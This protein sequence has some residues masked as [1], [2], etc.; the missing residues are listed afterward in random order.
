MIYSVHTKCILHS[1]EDSL[2]FDIDSSWPATDQHS[3]KPLFPERAST[4]LSTAYFLA[5]NID[6]LKMAVIE[7]CGFPAGY[8]VIRSV[9]SNRMLDVTMD[10]I[11]DGTEI[12]LWPEKDTS[13]V[14]SEHPVAFSLLRHS[15]Y[16]NT[17]SQAKPRCQ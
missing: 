8:F 13:L 3:P 11:E 2:G 14:E 7:T 9:A 12:I 15:S 16:I 6:I 1:L 4:P 5:I 17:S 10:D